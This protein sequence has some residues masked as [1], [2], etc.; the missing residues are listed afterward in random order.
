MGQSERVQIA[1]EGTKRNRS[2]EPGMGIV[3]GGC[4]CGGIREGS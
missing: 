2:L 4:M 3:I 1:F